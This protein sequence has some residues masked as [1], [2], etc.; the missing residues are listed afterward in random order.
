MHNYFTVGGSPASA[1]LKESR[2]EN[3]LIFNNAYL[4]DSLYAKVSFY[5]GGNIELLIT[6]N[7]S[8]NNDH[9][10]N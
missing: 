8:S 2:I 10:I 3:V 1:V 7:K 4:I 9:E 6:K 5:G